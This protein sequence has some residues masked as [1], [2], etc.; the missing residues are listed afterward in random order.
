MAIVLLTAVLI[1]SLVLIALGL[2][3]LWVM[4]VSAVA[5]NILVGGA[6]IGW[7]TLVAVTVLA[8]IAEILEFG[9]AGKY[10]RKYGGSRRASCAWRNG[11]PPSAAGSPPPR[12]STAR[13][14]TTTPRGAWRSLSGSLSS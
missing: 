12:A 7:L 11:I 1:L 5:Y 13:S 3:G 10:A 4:I 2:P 6:P 9:L 14:P 8:I